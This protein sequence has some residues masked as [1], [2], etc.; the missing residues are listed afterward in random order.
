MEHIDQSSSSSSMDYD[1]NDLQ[2]ILFDV[3]YDHFGFDPANLP[4][5][6]QLLEYADEDLIDY[7]KYHGGTSERDSLIDTIAKF[8][9]H[10]P[11]PCY[12]DGPVKNQAFV[13]ALKALK[14]KYKK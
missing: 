6:L 2:S 11:W 10:Q 13:D 7:Y 9:L 1:N 4:N 3:F 8:V 5:Y 14:R 12:A